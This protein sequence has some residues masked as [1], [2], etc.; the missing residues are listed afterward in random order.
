MPQ[1]IMPAPDEGAHSRRSDRSSCAASFAQMN[2]YLLLRRSSLF[3]R[4]ARWRIFCWSNSYDADGCRGNAG[5]L[6]PLPLSLDA[7][8]QGLNPGAREVAIGQVE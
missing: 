2:S 8:R 5:H 4:H 1:L 3:A 6:A 7:L